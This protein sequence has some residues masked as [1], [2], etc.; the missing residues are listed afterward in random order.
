MNGCSE[1]F[2]GAVALV[3]YSIRYKRGAAGGKIRERVVLVEQ[4]A[5]LPER[6]PYEKTVPVIAGQASDLQLFGYEADGGAEEAGKVWRRFRQELFLNDEDRPFAVL[7]WL[8]TLEGIRL[9]GA[10]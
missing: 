10:R 6:A 8:H 4:S 9:I 3:N 5:G 7:E 2:V 1:R